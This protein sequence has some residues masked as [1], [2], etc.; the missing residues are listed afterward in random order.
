MTGGGR[1]DAAA[2]AYWRRLLVCP[3]CR[4]DLGEASG[5]DALTC[6]ACRLEYPVV[7]GVPWMVAERARPWAERR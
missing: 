4:G 7:D 5:P 2:W 6:A 3:A 1:P